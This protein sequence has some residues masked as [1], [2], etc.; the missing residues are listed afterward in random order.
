[1]LQLFQS[2]V[3]DFSLDL[4][5][6]TLWDLKAPEAK[7]PGKLSTGNDVF[8]VLI[9]ECLLDGVQGSWGKYEILE[10]GDMALKIAKRLFALYSR[11]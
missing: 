7:S 11:D 10:V 6:P 4:G 5:I 1:M 3:S 8:K 9:E 2:V